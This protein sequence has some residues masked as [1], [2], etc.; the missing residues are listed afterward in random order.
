MLIFKIMIKELLFILREEGHKKVEN[1]LIE[2]GADRNIKDRWGKL[3][4]NYQHNNL[5]ICYSNNF[6]CISG[7]LVYFFKHR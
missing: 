3:P 4:K 7:I 6:I 2:N 1:F 5:Y